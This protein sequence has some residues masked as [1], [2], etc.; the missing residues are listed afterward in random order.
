MVAI[1]RCVREGAGSV[2]CGALCGALCGAS[3]VGG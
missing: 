2:R 1:C 3:G